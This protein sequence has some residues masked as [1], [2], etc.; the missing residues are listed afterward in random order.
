MKQTDTT[1]ILCTFARWEHVSFCYYLLAGDTVAPSRL[2]ARICH[3]FLVSFFFK[4]KQTISGSIG[5]IFVIF[6]PCDSICSKMTYLDFLDLFFLFLKGCCHG[7][8]LKWKNRFFR[9]PISF[10][11]LPF[12]NGFQYRYF[13][14]K[15]LNIMNFSTM[16][17]IL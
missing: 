8:K 10:V 5:P 16:C 6:A 4:W 2:L 1:C 15:R 13:H 14:F 11:A 12:Q 9:G 17:T 3:A 7:S